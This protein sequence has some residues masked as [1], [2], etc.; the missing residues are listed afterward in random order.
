QLLENKARFIG[1]VITGEVTARTADDM[2]DTVLTA[3]EV[4]A[5]ASGNPR[6]RE[7]FTIEN[8]LAR[9]DRL[10]RAW[11]DSRRSL[12]RKQQWAEVAITDRQQRI[13]KLMVAQRIYHAHTGAEFAVTLEKQAGEA[14]QVRYTQRAAAGEALLNLLEQYRTAALVQQQAIVRIIGAYQGFTMRVQAP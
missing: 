3:A 5:I 10:Y 9:L 2:G 13:A 14:A 1:Q 6:I 11:A 7:R 8:E 4:K 12:E